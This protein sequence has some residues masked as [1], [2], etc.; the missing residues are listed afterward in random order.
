MTVCTMNEYE[1]KNLGIHETA[2]KVDGAKANYAFPR[3]DCVKRSTYGVA[4]NAFPSRFPAH[5]AA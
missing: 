4:S 3:L 5:S 2:R 1:A